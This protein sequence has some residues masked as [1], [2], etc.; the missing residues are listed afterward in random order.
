MATLP[1]GTPPGTPSGTPRKTGK[2]VKRVRESPRTPPGTPMPYGTPA[3]PPPLHQAQ[4]NGL[5][6]GVQMLLPI[7]FSPNNPYTTPNQGIFLS[8]PDA[9]GGKQHNSHRE[10][11]NNSPGNNP[12]TKLF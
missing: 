10:E 8:T 2:G 5:H 12:C 4:P 7:N 3:T 6:F 9:P 1:P 11:E